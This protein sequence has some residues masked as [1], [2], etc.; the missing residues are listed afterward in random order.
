MPELKKEIKKTIV[1]ENAG[2]I[3]YI[4]LDSM[5]KFR[6]IK[7]VVPRGYLAVDCKG[8]YTS[9]VRDNQ[10]EIT[11]LVPDGVECIFL[12]P[13]T[14]N[15]AD[16]YL[17]DSIAHLW[18][19]NG[20]RACNRITL[21]I[22][23]N[24]YVK[25]IAAQHAIPCVEEPWIE[26]KRFPKR[27]TPEASGKDEFIIEYEELDRY[28][29][30]SGRVEIPAGV[31]IIK[32]K[33][34]F[35]NCSM[36][37]LIIPEGVKEIEK[38]AFSRCFGLQK[39]SF[40]DSLETIGEGAFE[41]CV[42]LPEVRLPKKVKVVDKE[43][44]FNCTSLKHVDLPEELRKI[45]QD[46]FANCPSLREITLPGKTR[47]IEER[48]FEKCDNLKTINFN[49]GLVY[50]G[51][52]TFANCP[53]IEYLVLPRS[54]QELGGVIG[55]SAEDDMLFRSI[56]DN[57][58]LPVFVYKGSVAERTAKDCG[59]KYEYIPEEPEEVE[60]VIVEEKTEEEIEKERLIQQEIY[61]T[62]KLG[63]E[64]KIDDLKHTLNE[65]VNDKNEQEEF[66]L[67]NKALFGQRARDRKAAQEKIQMLEEKIARFT[68]M[69]NDSEQSYREMFGQPEEEPEQT[70]QSGEIL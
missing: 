10:K 54:V 49:E 4:N 33:A 46:S 37:E 2:D 50:I 68:G 51:K 32:E 24:P 66:V 48:S 38:N 11:I 62:R 21:H 26:N 57:P 7:A 1:D 65:F 14:W 35:E 25:K 67:K 40:P 69:L 5:R 23:N 8:W 58:D 22:E 61:E 31:K 16:I 45:S 34:F 20:W 55:K 15:H 42:R 13:A 63:L 17:P 44:F 52:N 47:T 53:A 19:E 39:I 12:T 64:I 41:S 60:P 27:M 36:H 30:T 29:G 3:A 28:I 43:T 18:C 59:I 70:E 6:M 56:S 9:S